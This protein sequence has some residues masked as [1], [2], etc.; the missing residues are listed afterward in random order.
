M[1]TNDYELKYQEIQNN[2][3]KWVVHHIVQSSHNF[4]KLVNIYFWYPHRLEIFR[5]FCQEEMILVCG[6]KILY[7][8]SWN[9]ISYRR[10]V[11]SQK[12]CLLLYIQRYLCWVNVTVV[13]V[14]ALPNP[15]SAA[16]SNSKI[17]SLYSTLLYSRDT[18][19]IYSDFKSTSN[20]ISS[21]ASI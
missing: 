11:G 2:R 1:E 15:V 5:C 16:R 6:E 3:D 12:K 4:N 9:T 18:L 7:L 10:K 13:I 17:T 8:T 20:C 19:S 14:Q 21:L